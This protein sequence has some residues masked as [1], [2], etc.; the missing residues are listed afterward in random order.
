MAFYFI[1]QSPAVQTYLVGKLTDQLSRKYHTSITI[2]GVSVS[3]FNK[4][5]LD[6]VLVKDQQNDSL[7][8]VDELVASIHRF[9]FKKHSAAINKLELDRPF[10]KMKVDSAGNT[11]YQFLVD[12]FTSKDTLSPDVNYDFD[13]KR[14]ELKNASVGYAYV[15]TA[16]QHQIDLRNISLGVS[17][18][19]IQ[20][21][22]IA[23][24]INTLQLED[25][26]GFKLE[27]FSAHF[28]ANNDS[29]N[30]LKM[31]ARTSHSEITNLNFTMH[32]KPGKIDFGKMKVN[33]DLKK[34]SIGL[35]DMGIIFPMLRGMDENIDVEGQLSGTLADLKGKDITLSLGD[36][37]LLSFDFY[38][39]GLPHIEETYMHFDLK[40]SFADFNELGKV[41]LP[42][43]F[44]LTQLK[45]PAQLLDAGII[46]YEGNFTGF[47][48]DF[49]AY[50]TF[51][52]KWGV[53]TT[54]LSFVPSEGEKLE[55]NGKVQTVNFKM[56][57]LFQT[58]LL[59]DITFKGNIQ[60]LLNQYTN[61][62]S[63]ATLRHARVLVRVWGRA[64][65]SV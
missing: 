23:F 20:N 65:L 53:V 26:K 6:D 18:M 22:N 38:M 57:Q 15:D 3:F 4:V 37:T 19:G 24:L 9:N 35:K 7:L 13:L 55:V 52:S 36:H 45:L 28:L 39:N 56:G 2:K 34:S 51:K 1:L 33:L 5:V 60:G 50:G 11:N 47:L 40:Q 31:H 63:A 58:D 16:G 25:Q 21:N 44:P 62:F 42:D 8:F 12:L 32:R 10:I 61:N 14:L 46:E 59:N 49:V 48:S 27:E 29:I 43:S 41:K 64:L 54:D 17:D 30:L